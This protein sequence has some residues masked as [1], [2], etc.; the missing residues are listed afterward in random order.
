MLFFL[1]IVLIC[2]GMFIVF[3]FQIF[4]SVHLFGP[5]RLFGTLKHRNILNFTVN[6]MKFHNCY[7]TN[8]CLP[9]LLLDR[10]RLD[11]LRK[12][13]LPKNS[14]SFLVLILMWF[15]AGWTAQKLLKVSGFFEDVGLRWNGEP[16]LDI[17]GFSTEKSHSNTMQ[18][19]KRFLYNRLA[20][21]S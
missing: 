7:H 20:Q 11:D 10:R 21:I 4:H 17:I 19:L 15:G 5:V 16:G 18:K 12:P 6:T 14:S 9:L 2:T 8:D 13:P 3:F 1:P